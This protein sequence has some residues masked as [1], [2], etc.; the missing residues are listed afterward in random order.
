MCRFHAS[1]RYRRSALQRR[2][3]AALGQVRGRDTG[4]FQ[5]KLLF[6][7]LPPGLLETLKGCEGSVPHLLRGSLESAPAVQTAMAWTGQPQPRLCVVV[8]ITLWVAHV[9]MLAPRLQGARL[10]LGTFDCAEDA[11]L[12]YDAAARRIRGDLAICNFKLGELPAPEPA[13][14]SSVATSD[15]PADLPGCCCPGCCLWCTGLA[16]ASDLS[17]AAGLLHLCCAAP[18]ACALQGVWAASCADLLG[19]P[20]PAA[21][22]AVLP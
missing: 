17:R 4:P 12:A 9:L 11:A 19:A 21:A 3:A 6:H 2:Q 5:G 8:S 14:G 22:C 10:W 13:L 16:Q 15:L 1:Q 7:G 20:H 18:A